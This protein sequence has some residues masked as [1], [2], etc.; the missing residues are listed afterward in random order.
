MVKHQ[1]TDY[2]RDANLQNTLNSMGGLLIFIFH[3]YRLN[4]GL[5]LDVHNARDVTRAF[6]PKSR[7]LKLRDDYYYSN[8]IV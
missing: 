2:F 6:E 3:Y 1:R 7:M 8:L 5:N 4:M